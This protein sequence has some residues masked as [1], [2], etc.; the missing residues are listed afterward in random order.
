[1]KDECVMVFIHLRGSRRCLFVC[2][3]AG[4]VA[5]P[6]YTRAN[7]STIITRRVAFCSRLNNIFKTFQAGTT[8][9]ESWKKPDVTSIFQI[10]IEATQLRKATRLVN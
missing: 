9:N 5:R 8:S 2:G 7:W 3:L 6:E 4:T 10:Q 1:M